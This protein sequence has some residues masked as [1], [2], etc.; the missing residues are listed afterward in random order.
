MQVVSLN[1]AVIGM[2]C[3]QNPPAF[4]TIGHKDGIVRDNDL[5]ISA[6]GLMTIDPD[7]LAVTEI[8]KIKDVVP[9]SEIRAVGWGEVGVDASEPDAANSL[10]RPCGSGAV[11]GNH[12]YVADLPNGPGSH[13]RHS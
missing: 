12:P 8:F 1:N 9:S 7:S 6:P 4:D 3:H 5:I 13:C 11:I 2:S 10:A